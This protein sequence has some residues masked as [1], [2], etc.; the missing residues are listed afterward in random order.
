MAK[1]ELSTKRLQINR[2]NAMMVSIIAAASFVSIFSLVA[3]RALLSQRSY[4]ARVTKAK[5]EASDQLDSNLKAVNSLVTSYKSF[6]ETND[7]MLGGNPAGQGPKDGDNARIVLDALPSQY[8]FPALT[9]SLEN[10]LQSGGFKIDGLT[11]TDDEI[12][13][14]NKTS[15]NPTSQEMPFNLSV[16]TT[17]DQ[18]PKLI[19]LFEKSVRPFYFDHLSITGSQSSLK[20][21][22]VAKTYYQPAKNLNITTK[23]VK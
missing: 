5:Q 3:S 15:P 11:G 8:D 12:A 10:L 22:I 16:T 2:A 4:Q 20:L 19:D 23:E 13:Q 18:A 17:Y 1:L 7:N 14:Q 6:V 9:T 21:S